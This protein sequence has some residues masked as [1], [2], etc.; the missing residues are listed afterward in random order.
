[1]SQISDLYKKVKNLQEQ[2]DELKTE[3]KKIQNIIDAAG[4]TLPKKKTGDTPP[5]SNGKLVGNC[6][7]KLSYKELVVLQS[8]TT[9]LR[10]KRVM[11]IKLLNFTNR[12]LKSDPHF[13]HQVN[14]EKTS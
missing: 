3:N 11:I 6:G 2:I 8:I 1:M 9:Q 12:M 14:K 7:V 10:V 13:V 4:G 5:S